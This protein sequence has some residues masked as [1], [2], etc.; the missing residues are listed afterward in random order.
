MSGNSI[1]QALVSMFTKALPGIAKSLAKA[2]GRAF[3]NA[4]PLGKL[5]MIVVG[6]IGLTIAASALGIKDSDGLIGAAALVLG[7]FTIFSMIA[8]GGKR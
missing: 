5:M 6:V 3:L 2:I 8:T 4:S 1:L 7:M